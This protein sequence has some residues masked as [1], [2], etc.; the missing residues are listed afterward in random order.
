MSNESNEYIKLNVSCPCRECPTMNDIRNRAASWDCGCEMA[1]P[2]KNA[3]C[4]E[5]VH[6]DICDVFE[7]K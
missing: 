1:G 2:V 7:E 3:K 6:S 4:S 5:C